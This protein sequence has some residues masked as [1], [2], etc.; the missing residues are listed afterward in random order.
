MR[1]VILKSSI[2]F[3]L[4]AT[5]PI[6]LWEKEAVARLTVAGLLIGHPNYWYNHL[7]QTYSSM[8]KGVF[9]IIYKMIVIVGIT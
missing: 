9:I 2:H 5:A 4:H 3:L 1:F 8:L 6:A 7:L